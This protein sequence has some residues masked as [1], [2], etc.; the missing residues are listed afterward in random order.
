MTIADV[1][2]ALNEMVAVDGICGV[3]IVK[4]GH[5]GLAGKIP[6]LVRMN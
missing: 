6:P 5:V 2:P 3:M 1:E 4:D